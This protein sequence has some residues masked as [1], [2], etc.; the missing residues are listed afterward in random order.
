MTT[1]VNPTTHL[2]AGPIL[3]SSEASVVL[4]HP[5]I[6][7]TQEPAHLS[8]YSSDDPRCG[9]GAK[10]L[11][12]KL[13]TDVY[14][15]K[16]FITQDQLDPES[17][18]YIDGYA[19][20]STYFLV[21]NGQK[22]A[23]ARQIKA[24]KESGFDS[25]PTT[26]YFSLDAGKMAEV[27]G[28]RSIGD[29]KPKEVV[30]ISGLAALR[31]DGGVIGS[32]DAVIALYSQMLKTSLEHGHKLW[33]QNVD[34]TFLRI[35][36]GMVGKEQVHVL[37]AAREYMGPPTIPVG[38]NPQEI[39]RKILSSEDLA[40]SQYKH[41]LQAVFAGIDDRKVP[42]DIRALFRSN[43]IAPKEYSQ[44]VELVKKP[45]V[46][47][48]IIAVGYSASRD[49]AASTVDQFQGDLVT[50]MS[51]DIGTAVPY[52]YGLA[53]MLTGKTVGQR[54]L[55]TSIA[56]PSFLAPYV[57][58]WK[59]GHNYPGYVKGIAAGMA[60]VAALK[61]GISFLTRRHRG[62]VNTLALE[63]AWAPLPEEA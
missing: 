25:L 26:H 23:T 24:D 6:L 11:S 32:L 27:A 18:L 36:S 28:V 60:G 1:T 63:Q 42:H 44:V 37:G 57:Y 54:L 48:G 8:I 7:E 53:K 12:Q 5:E 15:E 22:I 19:D 9:D 39:V 31:K 29:L 59:E 2:P 49:L 55:G 40:T 13:S 47:L 62:K 38:L 56:I 4:D 43:G 51:I 34:P 41:H 16:D 17:G 10:Y 33:V 3:G 30:E 58:F 21:V 61:E 50:L 35:L 46:A 52:A 45:E 20:R 14:L